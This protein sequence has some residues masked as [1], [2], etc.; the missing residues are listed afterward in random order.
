MLSSRL[1]DLQQW[2]E[3]C[4]LRRGGLLLLLASILVYAG[5]PAEELTF[6]NGIIVGEDTRLRSFD[7]GSLQEI[8]QNNYWWPTL[9]SSLYR[10]LTTLSFWIEYSFL[11]YGSTPFGYQL[12]NLLLNLGNALLVILLARRMGLKPVASMVVAGVVALHPIT[13]EVV[14]N[15]VGRSDLFTCAAVLG[16]L[17]FYFRSMEGDSRGERMKWMGACG[18]CAF[19]GVLSK[20]SAVALPVLVVWHGCCRVGELRSPA[21]RGLWL[22]DAGRAL[23]CLLPSVVFLAVVR[24]HFSNALPGLSDHPFIDNPL[25]AEGWLVSLLSAFGVW[26]M[27]IHALFLPLALSSDYSFD[28]IPVA[29]WAV[30]NRTFWWGLGTITVFAAVPILL[31]VF[32]RRLPANL[33][34]LL[35]AYLIAALPTSNVL[36]KIGSIR[37]DR[38]HYLPS[39]FLW[40]GLALV[41]KCLLEWVARKDR[42]TA[43]VLQTR[44]AWV[45]GAWC[46]CLVLL[47]HLRCYDWRSNLTLWQSAME[48]APGSV[49]SQA[50]VANERLR[51]REDAETALEAMQ[52]IDAA[53]APYREKHVDPAD[54]PLVLFS[55][56]GAFA[57]SLYD[58]LSRDPLRKEEAKMHLE[59]GLKWLEKGLEHEAAM[60]RRWAERWGGGD[61]AQA[62]KYS[63]LRENY[64]R[65][66]QRA[67]RIDEAVAMLDEILEK[68][69]HDVE[70]RKFKGITLAKAGRSEEA[71]EEL[72]L[73]ALMTPEHG[74]FLGSLS[75][76]L[77]DLAPGSAPAHRGPSGA[78]GLDLDDPTVKD[79]LAQAGERYL[80]MLLGASDELGAARLKR[81]LRIFYGVNLSG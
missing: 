58:D 36:I 62:P 27:E 40:I 1:A 74:E 32:R 47:A 77:Q 24:H 29:D 22:A 31:L 6:D 35:G 11:G 65:A 49:K 8:V 61:L 69:W 33:V 45:A 17:L 68:H 54:W 75:A 52:R 7:A 21:T 14:A 30:G 26:G 34:F 5:M 13:V 37:A 43:L 60:R 76:A 3:K 56:Y 28:A 23:L 16:G 20:E 70:I 51:V 67:G 81:T 64:A 9:A 72:M 57:S 41:L 25:M 80:E 15:I 39:V 79:A 12:T 59:N 19:L 42:Q 38:F 48:N 18:L 71:V 2:L 66:L 4:P 10:P 78:L 63:R 73:L 55:D 44:F 53:L 50:A 46:V